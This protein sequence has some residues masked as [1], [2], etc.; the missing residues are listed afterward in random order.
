[1]CDIE[2]DSACPVWHEVQRT[3]RKQHDCD[4]CGEVIAPGNRYRRTGILW[5]GGWQTWKHCT[6]CAAILD[7]LRPRLGECF[8]TDTLSL[9][10]GEVWS[11]APPHVAALAFM[12]P[13][14]EG[15]SDAG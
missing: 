10:C 15:A 12:I 11:D 8:T 2:A 5:D 14:D 13:S 6:R 1:M 7:A 4:G 9:N 3:S